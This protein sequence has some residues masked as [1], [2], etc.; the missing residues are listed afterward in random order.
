MLLGLH[1]QF[2]NQLVDIALVKN[3]ALVGAE[4]AVALAH[5]REDA[6]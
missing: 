2:L 4:I 3:N 5:L 6:N 1:K